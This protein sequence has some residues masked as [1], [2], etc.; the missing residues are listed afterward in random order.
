VNIKIMGFTCNVCL[1]PECTLCQRLS[2]TVREVAGELGIEANI[3]EVKDILT[4]ARYPGM[5]G[6]CLL[7]VP[8]LVVNDKL[9]CAGRLPG[10]EEVTR[11]ILNAAADD[12]RADAVKLH[13]A[14]K[15]RS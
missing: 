7:N 8:G 9:V 6:C 15:G 5:K 2:D 4:I 14:E 3:E 11:F 12:G 13:T 1:G 10:R